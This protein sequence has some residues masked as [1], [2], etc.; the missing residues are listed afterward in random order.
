MWDP[1]ECKA[2]IV[3]LQRDNSLTLVNISINLV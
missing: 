1:I 3:N 2:Y